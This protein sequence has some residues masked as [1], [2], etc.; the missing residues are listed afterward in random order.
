MG[1]KPS[2]EKVSLYVRKESN[3]VKESDEDEKD[4][5]RGATTKKFMDSMARKSMEVPADF[6]DTIKEEK[7]EK[8]GQQIA[9]KYPFNRTQTPNSLREHLKETLTKNLGGSA[10]D[11]AETIEH[12]KNDE[13]LDTF[14]IDNENVES[15]SVQRKAFR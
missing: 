9:K 2:E 8:P 13:I 10:N 12:F 14:N 11:I 4:P 15:P 1:R 5:K 6:L 7:T 3:E